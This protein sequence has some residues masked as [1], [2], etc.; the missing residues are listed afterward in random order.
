MFSSDQIVFSAHL[1]RRFAY[2]ARYLLEH[3]QALLITQKNGEKLVLVNA[4]IFENLLKQQ[5]SQSDLK[6]NF[7]P[8]IDT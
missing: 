7:G 2:Y 8:S 3:P 5:F 4:E 1:V 6:L